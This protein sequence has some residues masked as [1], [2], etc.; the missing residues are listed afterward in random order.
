MRLI[1]AILGVATYV[2]DVDTGRVE[3]ESA[4]ATTLLRVGSLG[5]S[6]QNPFTGAPMTVREAI[7]LCAFWREVI[8][9]NRKLG[10]GLGFAFWKQAHV[11]PLL[12]GGTGAFAFLKNADEAISGAPVAVWRSRVPTKD[13]R[14]LERAGVPMIEV[15]D[16]FLRSQGL[17]ADC[18]PPLSITVDELG[19][20]FDPAQPSEL[21]HLLQEA[22]FDEALVGRARRL[23]EIIVTAGLGK[24]ERSGGPAIERR[25]R[26]R[27]YILV[28][29]QV[30]DDRSVLTG[31][32]GLVSNQALLE[33]VRA[34]APEAYIIY[35]P[36]PDVVAGHRRGAITERM[37]RGLADE[38]VTHEPISKLIDK[39]DE[40]HVNTSLAGFEALMRGRP[41]TTYGA[42]FYAGWGLTNDLGL[43]PQRR[44]AKRTLDEVVAAALI[45]YPRY[46]DP[47]T[48]LP[49]P[50]ETVVDRL[51]SAVAEST[52]L[53]VTFRRL[54][55]RLMRRFRS[56]AK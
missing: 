17:G 47:V 13:L 19:P 18:V 27:R 34:L 45:L 23:R 21:E 48:G 26:D 12:F 40:V 15:E 46:L 56:F 14:A 30:E 54:Q 29:G 16:G 33:R 28:P 43:V 10:G 11:A 31:G 44:T 3:P 50:A 42:P 37:C 32:G 51:S 35:K 53:L 41:V 55:G 39:A 38:I 4:A 5:C 22:E 24:Y 1:A 20:Y 49:C 36:H 8:D 6:H 52:G 9:R 25:E 2:R 7:Q